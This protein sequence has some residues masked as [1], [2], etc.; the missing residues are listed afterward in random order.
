MLISISIAT[1]IIMI[2][3]ISANSNIYDHSKSFSDHGFIDWKQGIT[4]YK[5]NDT[6]YIYVTKPEQ[7]IRYK[8][9]VEKVGLDSTDVRKDEEY[10]VNPIDYK[11]SLVGFFVRLKLVEKV[12]T[13]LLD[14]DSLRVNGLKNAPQGPKKLSGDL[15]SYI[16]D[17][18]SLSFDGLI[19]EELIGIKKSLDLSSKERKKLIE[20]APKKPKKI[21]VVTY[22]YER[23]PDIVAEALIRANGICEQCKLSAPFNRKK[24]NTPYLEVHH[25]IRLADGGEDTLS[26]V[27]ALCPNCHRQMHYGL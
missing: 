11:Q 24:D 23:S 5:I 19:E 10:W 1:R 13:K 14:L 4:K 20:K 17:N 18:F 25:K 21:T 16:E 27:I 8:C 26:N 15:L 6:V 7:K 12:N 22:V 9:I 3:L 2:W